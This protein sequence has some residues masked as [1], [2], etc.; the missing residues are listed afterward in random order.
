M[1]AADQ[2]K[3]PTSPP[4]GG[5]DDIIE[6]TE[7]VLDF[8]S[9]TD[10]LA[11]LKSPPPS[12]EEMTEAA[13]VEAEESLND[14]LASLPDLPD[15]LDIPTAAPPPETR[16]PEQDLRQELAERLDEAELQDLV[17]QVVQETVERLAREMLPEMA[18][19]AIEREVNLLKKRLT[20]T[21]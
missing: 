10:D 18:T 6:L 19:A 2:A 8:R 20:E 17:R 13:L 15:D 5:E 14:V 21:D 1:S 16:A 3:P 9:G 12:P 7:V 4:P 11:A